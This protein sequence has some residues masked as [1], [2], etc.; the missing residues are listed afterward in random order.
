MSYLFSRCVEEYFLGRGAKLTSTSSF[1]KRSGRPISLKQFFEYL[2]VFVRGLIVA[3]C[4]VQEYLLEE[5]VLNIKLQSKLK[6]AYCLHTEK[7]SMSN[8]AIRC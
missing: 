1:T 8:K 6:L 5:K 3:I 2:G 7:V 4:M